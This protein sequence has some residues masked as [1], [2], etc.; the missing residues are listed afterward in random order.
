MTEKKLM[1]SKLTRAMQA[2]QN[3]R[4]IIPQ[5]A[6]DAVIKKYGEPAVRRALN[7]YLN[8]ARAKNR[9]LRQKADA[10]AALEYA[11]KYLARLDLAVNPRKT[12]IYHAEKGLHY[13]GERLLLKKRGPYEE[14][15]HVPRE[16]MGKATR[17]VATPLALPVATE[18]TPTQEER[19]V[20]STSP[21]R[22]R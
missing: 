12:T 11:R 15:V 3:Y 13:L 4:E 14:L 19:W 6:I 22:A 9:L 18:A 21:N 8:N 5:L 17:A 10:E 2:E 20:P 7:R 16:R 1:P